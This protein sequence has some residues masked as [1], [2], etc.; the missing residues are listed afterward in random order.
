[1]IQVLSGLMPNGWVVRQDEQTLFG[2]KHDSPRDQGRILA[3]QRVRLFEGGVLLP[4]FNLFH[5]SH[6]WVPT[7]VPS[8]GGL[9]Y[10]I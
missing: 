9:T 1:M 3:P 4:Q 6:S 2:G 10:F 7:R 8:Y 5:F